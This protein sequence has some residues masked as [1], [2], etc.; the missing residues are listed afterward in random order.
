M[1]ELRERHGWVR[2]GSAL[3]VEDELWVATFNKHR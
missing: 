2:L 3:K 1:S